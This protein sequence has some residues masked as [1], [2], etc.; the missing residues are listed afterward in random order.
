MLGYSSVSH[1]IGL[2]KILSSKAAL[3]KR[4]E[5]ARRKQL[6]ASIFCREKVTASNKVAESV[7]TKEIQRSV[8]ILRE[9]RAKVF[10]EIGSQGRIGPSLSK[11]VSLRV[12][13]IAFDVFKSVALFEAWASQHAPIDLSRCHCPPVGRRSVT[14]GTPYS[15][16]GRR[17]LPSR[18]VLH[19]AKLGKEREVTDL[20]SRR[21]HSVHKILSRI[22]CKLEKGEKSPL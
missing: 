10:S 6:R 3:A 14:S 18:Y 19:I 16:G 15:C 9:G 11:E 20:C 7:Y 4:A 8:S 22:L 13:A 12:M 1:G 2:L 5:N 21:L 17:S